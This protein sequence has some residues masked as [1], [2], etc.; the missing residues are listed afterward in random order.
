MRY[1]PDQAITMGIGT[2]MDAKEIVLIAT[3]EHKADPIYKSVEG[4]LSKKVIAAVLQKHKNAKFFLDESAASKLTRNKKPWLLKQ[5]LNPKECI[6]AL[7]SISKTEDKPLENIIINDTITNNMP[8]ISNNLPQIKQETID[9][10]KSKIYQLPKGKRIL[11]FSPHPDDDIISM[12]GTMLKLA[13]DNDVY[14]SYMTPGYTAVFD[15]DVEK[16]IDQR[17]RFEEK[18]PYCKNKD[19]EEFYDTILKF[20]DE[21]KKHRFG[22]VDITDVRTIKTIIRQSEADSVCRY[23]GVKDWFFLNLPFYD[24]GKARKKPI[25]KEDIN[26]VTQNIIDIAPEIIF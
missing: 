13:I 8:Q 24:S 17:K 4:D 26:I 6:R 22:L 1:V 25:G 2:I 21:K 18:F 23:A 7:V 3:G 5:D 10:L 19:Q 16:L 12:G 9:K 11:I 20:L 14:V 15:H